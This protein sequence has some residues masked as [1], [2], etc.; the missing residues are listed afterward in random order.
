[1]TARDRLEVGASAHRTLT[2]TSEIVQAF[3]DVSGDHNPL[4]LDDAYAAT[5]MFGR[6]IAHGLIAASQI[7]AILANDLPG[8]G[9]IYL[10]QALEF[11]A[12]VFI[13]DTIRATVTVS[14]VDDRD[15]VALDTSVTNGA[16]K[17]VLSGS[18]LVLS[19]SE[20]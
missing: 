12:P 19:P 13:G 4:H 1:M 2:V 9:T 10:S 11:K 7:S 15:R 3:A 14:S 6:R 16:G 20:K 5:T 17:L 18:A 8:P